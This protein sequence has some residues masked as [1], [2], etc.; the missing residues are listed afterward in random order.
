MANLQELVNATTQFEFPEDKD[1]ATSERDYFLAHVVV[2]TS[3]TTVG[4]NDP[5]VKVQLMTIH[6]A[7][8]LE[9]SVVFM[10]GMA[11]GL[12]PHYACSQEAKQLEEER[13]LC[14]VGM[15]RAM[16]QLYLTCAK[17][18]MTYG[19]IYQTQKASRFLREIPKKYKKSIK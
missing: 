15:T 18:R 12:F 17:Y 10:V 11:E 7:K 8:G 19:S 1:I 5:L 6:A 13:R 16:Q 2:D 9:F 4:V 14:Y 3:E